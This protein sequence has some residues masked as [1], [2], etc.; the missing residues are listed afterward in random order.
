MTNVCDGGRFEGYSDPSDL[1][2]TRV[3]LGEDAMRDSY[4]GADCPYGN[5][6]CKHNAI[7]YRHL[8]DVA[9]LMER[10][11]VAGT[12]FQFVIIILWPEIQFMPQYCWW[13]QAEMDLNGRKS[14]SGGK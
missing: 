1:G 4:A 2:A 5:M 3:A 13:A 12:D 11:W 9:S 6:R 8:L 14:C 7:P 10:G